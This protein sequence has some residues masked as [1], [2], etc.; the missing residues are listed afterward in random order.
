MS[1]SLLMDLDDTLLENNIDSFLPHY[2]QAFGQAVAPYMDPK[3]FTRKLLAGTQAMVK[4]RNPDCTLQDAFEAVFFPGLG[5]DEHLFRQVAEQFYADVFPD[6]QRLTRPATDGPALMNEV[7]RRGYPVVIAT[8]P[9]FPLT[10]IQ[11]RINWAGLPA[12]QFQFDLVTS[13]ETFHFAKPDPAFFAEAMAGLGW[14]DGPIVIV[15]DDI[16]REIVPG[17]QLGLPVFWI[18][19]NGVDVPAEAAGPSGRGALKDFLPWLDRTQPEALLP[20]FS[21]P[22]ALV[23][24]LRSTPAA[25]DTFFRPLSDAQ[26]AIRPAAQEWSLG[27]IACHLR[28]VE[29]EVNLRRVQKALAEDNPF[30]PGEDTDRWSEE[31][32]YHMQDGRHARGAFT[33]ARMELLSLLDGLSPDDWQRSVRHAIFGPTRLF[34]MVSF[35]AA[36]DRLHVRQAI[37]ARKAILQF[38]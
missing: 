19:R 9:L 34:E 38:D 21:S 23:A 13:Y 17:R 8:N 31:R 6:L 30:I 3:E 10:A 37:A 2:L 15:G 5:M 1:Y 12:E 29:A 25:M 22:A 16:D 36:H 14:P 18:E 32:Q 35:M 33:A 4:N 24:I 28:D 11:Q 26:I 20:D 7:L 27:E